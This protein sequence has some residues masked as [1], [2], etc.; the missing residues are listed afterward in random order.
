VLARIRRRRIESG[1]SEKTTELFTAV[2]TM[3]EFDLSPGQWRRLSRRD[4]KILHYFQ[5]VSE[6]HLDVM[7]ERMRQESEQQRQ[8]TKMPKLIR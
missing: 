7:R 4:K 6:F 2:G 1:G 8:M 5:L 3:K